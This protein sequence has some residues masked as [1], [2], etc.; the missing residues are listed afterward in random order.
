MELVPGELAASSLI[1]LVETI[2]IANL[3]ADHIVELESETAANHDV[4]ML[5]V[6]QREHVSVD[7]AEGCL[8]LESIINGRT[9][10][11]P[12]NEA[13]TEFEADIEHNRDRNTHQLVVY[14]VLTLGSIVEINTRSNAD[15]TCEANVVVEAC[16]E[17][18]KVFL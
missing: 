18:G 12:D 3:E 14:R 4:Q 9:C 7:T 1:D 2:V 10:I 16:I 17:T 5:I 15:R 6:I 8:I 13:V 11:R